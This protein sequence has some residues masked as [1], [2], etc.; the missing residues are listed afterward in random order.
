LRNPDF[1]ALAR[2]HGALGETVAR[3][4]GFAPAFGR[5]LAAGRPALL[6]L[7]LDPAALTHRTPAAP[8]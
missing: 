7:K 3:T 5:A 6:H 1:A 4:D 2:A 8:G